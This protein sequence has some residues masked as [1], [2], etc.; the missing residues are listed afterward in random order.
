MPSIQ[1]CLTPTLGGNTQKIFHIGRHKINAPNSCCY[2]S[3]IFIAIERHG[4]C[5]SYSEKKSIEK[6]EQVSKQ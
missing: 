1:K 6:N 4:L 3:S 2:L 5:K